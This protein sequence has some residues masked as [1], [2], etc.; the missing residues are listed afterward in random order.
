MEDRMK[1]SP[2]LRQVSEPDA[3]LRVVGPNEQPT[4]TTSCCPNPNCAKRKQ[5]LAERR[6][7]VKALQA[8]LET[9]TRNFVRQLEKADRMLAS[10]RREATAH[11]DKR[12]DHLGY[13][14]VQK[15]RP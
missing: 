13:K 1:T 10:L 11:I 15:R 6:K 2:N 9:A 3:D 5:A 4:T 14:S 12:A 7:E 8:Q